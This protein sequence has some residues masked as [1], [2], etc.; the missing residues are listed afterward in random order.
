MTYYDNV[1]L[2]GGEIPIESGDLK[3]DLNVIKMVTSTLMEVNFLK[4]SSTL[5]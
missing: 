2:G 4:V 5:V 3:Y 1:E